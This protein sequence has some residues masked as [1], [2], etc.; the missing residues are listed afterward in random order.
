MKNMIKVA[1]QKSWKWFI[2]LVV[3]LGLLFLIT[4][5]WT[6]VCFAKTGIGIQTGPGDYS[7]VS[8]RYLS[9]TS[10]GFQGIGEFELSEKRY[11]FTLAGRALYR[12]KNEEKLDLYMGLGLQGWL[13]YEIE[14]RETEKESGITLE[15]LFGGEYPIAKD[16]YLNLEIGTRGRG[17][18]IYLNKLGIRMYSIGIGIGIHYYF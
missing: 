3:Q 13:K 10:F 11:Y 6:I 8:I 17:I 18:G 9:K 15:A 5:L 1:K 4:T 16:I 12:V 14:E 7:G 2:K